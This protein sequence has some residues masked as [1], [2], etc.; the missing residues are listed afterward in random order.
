MKEA[1]DILRSQ[2]SSLPANHSDKMGIE[3]MII[4]GEGWHYRNGVIEQP[5]LKPRDFQMKQE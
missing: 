1:V 2:L 3:A 5:V 4:L